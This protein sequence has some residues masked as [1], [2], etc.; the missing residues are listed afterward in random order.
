M[1]VRLD[2]AEIDAVLAS[3]MSGVLTTLRA[4]GWPVSLPMWFVVVDGRVFVR[5]P[6]R[7]RKVDRVRRD[8]RVSFVVESGER[9]EE[10]VA[11]VLTAR[12][13]V[14]EDDAVRAAV[15]AAFDAK[16]RALRPDTATLPEATRRHYGVG[17]A[18]LRLDPAGRPI[19]WDNR[20]IRR[21]RAVDEEAATWR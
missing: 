9:W 14:V 4:D 11:V 17:T 12:A 2:Q 18:V 16:Y 3:S 15:A 7:S 8:D 19:T 5:T 21:V 6:A 10:L 20:K 13:T 1:S